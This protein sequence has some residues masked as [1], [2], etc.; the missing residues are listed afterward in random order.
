[1]PSI[2]ILVSATA[3][4]SRREIGQMS[5]L[6][7]NDDYCRQE[8]NAARAIFS[9]K[10]TTRVQYHSMQNTLGYMYLYCSEK[11]K[12]MVW[13]HV[14]DASVRELYFETQIWRNSL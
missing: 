8:L 7:E 3:R 10:D 6:L 1:M 4:T 2:L 5:K 11:M 9:A 12:S 14:I 13:A